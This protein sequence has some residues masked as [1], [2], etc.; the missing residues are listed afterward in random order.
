MITI[1]QPNNSLLL[2]ASIL[3]QLPIADADISLYRQLD[4]GQPYDEILQELID[5]TA[6]CQQEVTIYG[7]RHLQPRLSA[8]YGS[9]DL[10]YS[11]SGITV[12]P[13]RWNQTLLRLKSRI[14]SLVSH[15]FN[16]VLLNYYR[17]QRDGMGMH[18]DDESDLGQQPVIASLSLGDERIFLLR[19]RHLKEINTLK[20]PLPSSSI[21]LMNGN[22]QSFWK[23]GIAKEKHPCGPRIN[24]TF[25]SIIINQ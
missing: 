23:H 15:S 7:K 24:L 19:H 2:E 20:L 10:N 11:Y 17:D 1:D 13:L 9:K 6:W 12:T 21:L 16:S 4:L 3:E 8:W 18:S 14:E 25:R 22:T 5:G